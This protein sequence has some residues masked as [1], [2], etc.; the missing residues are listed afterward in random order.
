MDWVGEVWKRDE[1]TWVERAW[2]VGEVV[3]LGSVLSCESVSEQ[4]RQC[5]AE[6]VLDANGDFS[7]LC[8][9]VYECV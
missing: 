3:V 7:V 5:D 9:C 4:S 1:Y 6:R 8:M 2:M